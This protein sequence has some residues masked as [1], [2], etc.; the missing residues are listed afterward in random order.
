MWILAGLNHK[1]IEAGRSVEKY[2]RVLSE[3][4]NGISDLCKIMLRKFF[5]AD[6]AINRHEDVGHQGD[7]RLVCAD[8]RSRLFTANVLLASG[9]RQH[10]TTLPAAINSLAGKTARHLSHIRFS[11]SDHATVGASKAHGHTK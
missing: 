2:I 10:K 8:V 3:L 5:Q 1:F 9:K 4:L 7:K 6:F 11:R